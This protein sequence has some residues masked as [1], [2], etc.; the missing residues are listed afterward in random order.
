MVECPNCKHQNK[1]S[2]LFCETCGESI[3]TQCPNCDALNEKDFIYCFQCGRDISNLGSLENISEA[4]PETI[5]ETSKDENIV[6]DV[7]QNSK[8]YAAVYLVKR[9]ISLGI[10]WYLTISLIAYFW[11]YFINWAF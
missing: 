1:E 7:R 2:F 8:S 4:V 10:F 9:F 3:K 6:L 5:I 11:P